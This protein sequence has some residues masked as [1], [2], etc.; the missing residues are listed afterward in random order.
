MENDFEQFISYFSVDVQVSGEFNTIIDG[1]K[2]PAQSNAFSYQEFKDAMQYSL[3]DPDI[4]MI[5]EVLDQSM[6]Y[7]NETNNIV[8]QRQIKYSYVMPFGKAVDYR[9]ET[10]S[11]MPILKNDDANIAPSTT[12]MSFDINA[13]EYQV[14][15]LHVE[16]N[17]SVITALSAD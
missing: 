11:L 2:Q 3:N 9:D 10:I 5:I 8:V 15:K 17:M 6:S 13:T 14:V 16:S 4:K 1:E 7:N 12:S